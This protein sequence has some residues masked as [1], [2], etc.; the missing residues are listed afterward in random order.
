MKTATKIADMKSCHVSTVRRA[1][2]EGHLTAIQF[3]ALY[4]IVEDEN[5]RNWV[6]RRLGRPRKASAVKEPVEVTA[7]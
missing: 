7:V 3:G 5:L 6:P 1:L 4:L 2:K